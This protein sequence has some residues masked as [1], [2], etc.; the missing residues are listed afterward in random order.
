METQD[1]FRG[2][3]EPGHQV[4]RDLIV[5]HEHGAAKVAHL[6]DV[7]APVD[8]DV[9]G[10]DVRMQDAA[11]LHEVQRH[12]HL[13]GHGADSVQSEADALAVLLSQLP[14]V[15][16]LQSVKEVISNAVL[17]RQVPTPLRPDGHVPSGIKWC[18]CL[19][20]SAKQS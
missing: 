7:V 8:Q 16:L 3:V 5:A 6:N 4:W 19:I 11:L 18:E 10:L 13:G 15:G 14:Q 9:V 17:G 20:F 12:Q 1:D 2:S